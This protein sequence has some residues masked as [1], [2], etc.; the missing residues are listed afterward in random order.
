MPPGRRYP[1]PPTRY[2]LEPPRSPGGAPPPV[3]SRALARGAQ[4][5]PAPARARVVQRAD[6]SFFDRLEARGG[7]NMWLRGRTAYAIP[8]WTPPV[9]HPAGAASA[10][11]VA[12]MATLYQL[13]AAQPVPVGPIPAINLAA[14]AG[15]SWQGAIK[16]KIQSIQASRD[17]DRANIRDVHDNIANHLPANVNLATLSQNA[18]SDKQF[19]YFG[20]AV[21]ETRNSNYLEYHTGGG[22][23]RIVYDWYNDR[24]YV[25]TTHYNTWHFSTEGAVHRNPWIEII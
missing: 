13:V 25:G 16:T 24:F 5:K 23:I 6:L 21:T 4:A 12:M 18:L 17:V 3:P 2:A 10:D 8:A 11:E 19:A 14:L 15:D 20:Y 22:P 7:A 1:P 9:A